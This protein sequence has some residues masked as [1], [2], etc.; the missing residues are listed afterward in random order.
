LEKEQ[1]EEDFSIKTIDFDLSGSDIIHT[2]QAVKDLDILIAPFGN[3]LGSGFFTKNDLVLISISAA[4]Y[5]LCDVCEV[6]S[7]KVKI[8]GPRCRIPIG[9][10]LFQIK[11]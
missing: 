1:G 2:A 6:A 9:W 10:L 11:G 3:G 5:D 7:M 4:W 8:L